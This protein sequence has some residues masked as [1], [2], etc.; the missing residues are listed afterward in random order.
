MD[1]LMSVLNYTALLAVGLACSHNVGK[2]REINRK[3]NRILNCKE[4][5]PLSVQNVAKLEVAKGEGERVAYIEI[6]RSK[7]N[8][9][10]SSFIH[11]MQSISLMEVQLHDDHILEGVSGNGFDY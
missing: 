3:K 7:S 2:S 9:T 4:E 5:Y 11:R 6:D 1:A 8:I 10:P